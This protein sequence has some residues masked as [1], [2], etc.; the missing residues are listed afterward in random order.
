MIESAM[1]QLVVR[2]LKPLHAL[3]V[4]NP[5]H[6]GTPDI[7]YVGGWIELKSTSDWPARAA[8]L[9]RCEHFTPQQRIWLTRRCAAGGRADLLFSV[10]REWFCMNGVSAA[11]HLGKTTRSQ[12][13]DQV[14]CFW[15]RTPTSEELLTCF[16]VEI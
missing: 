6:P 8:T 14:D 13:L 15:E 12:L 9:F 3:S 11:E 1:R 10:G 5:T 2:A 16:Q 7:N 4:E